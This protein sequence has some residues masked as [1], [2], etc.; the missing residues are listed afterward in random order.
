MMNREHAKALIRSFSFDEVEVIEPSLQEALELATEDRQLGEWLSRECGADASFVRFLFHG[1]IPEDLKK[2]IIDVLESGGEIVDEIACEA[3]AAPKSVEVEKSPEV[4]EAEDDSGSLSV[5]TQRKLGNRLLNW[6]F[7]I[8]VIGLILISMAFVYQFFSGAGEGRLQGSTSE[9]VVGATVAMIESPFFTLDLQN[10]RPGVLYDW[11]ESQ[12]FPFPQNL[13]GKMSQMKT[14]GCRTLRV[15]GGERPGSLVSYRNGEE[16][17]HLLT[18]ERRSVLSENTQVPKNLWGDWSQVR[19]HRQW[20]A[21]PWYHGEYAFF[22]LRE[23]KH[24]GSI[25]F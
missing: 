16:L 7:S 15:G 21:L 25:D 3:Y 24:L 6:S 9:E 12:G 19:G 1:V 23:K 4:V 13:P 20:V 10:D 22:L 5:R 11:L 2:S 14:V 17:I 8:V 18:I